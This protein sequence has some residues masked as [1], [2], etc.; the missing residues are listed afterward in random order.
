MTV[1]TAI[2]LDKRIARARGKKKPPSPIPKNEANRTFPVCVRVT[3]QRDF[4]R[5]PIG[6]RMTPAD[7]GKLDSPNLGE[8]LRKVKETTAKEEKRA[9]KIIENLRIFSFEEFATQFGS[10][11]TRNRKSRKKDFPL[12]DGDPKPAQGWQPRAKREKF[13]NQFG[14]RKYPRNKSEIDFKAMGEVAVWYGVYIVRLEAKDQVT[15]AGIYLSSLTNLLAYHP[16]LR[17]DDITDVWLFRYE[18]EMKSKGRSITTISMYLRCLRR[19]FNMVTRKKIVDR[20]LYPFGQDLYVIPAP[21]KKKKALKM[22]DIER[23]FQYRCD[24]PIRMMC[25]Y[26]WFFMYVGNGMNPKDMCLLLFKDISERFCRFIRAK[27]ENT[28]RGDEQYVTFFCDDFVLSVIQRYGNSGNS[29]DDYL[30]PFL[31]PG[32]DAYAIREA[33]QKI[34]HLIRDHMHA[35]ASELGIDLL[36]GA[37]D[38]RRAMANAMKKAGKTTEFIRELMGHKSAKTTQDYLDDYDDETKADNVTV[39]LPFHATSPY[40]EGMELPES[41]REPNLENQLSITKTSTHEHVL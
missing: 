27:T 18:K 34:A 9:Q 38:A 6:I 2:V 17:F 23:L 25:L 33:V 22:P 35:I 14:G 37:K 7:F 24:N 5:Y 1:T 31:Q 36:P 28:T 11:Q 41:L 39:L 16:N 12:A 15:T 20:D 4:R 26:L 3:Y 40:R 30:F 8:K 29:P 19:I 10:F 21:R 13:V 32:M